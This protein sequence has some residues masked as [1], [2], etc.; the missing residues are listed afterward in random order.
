MFHN[1]IVSLPLHEDLQS[2]P[3]MLL[4]GTPWQVLWAESLPQS[5][6]MGGLDPDI[7]DN[8][9]A[10]AQP[11]P[12]PKHHQAKVSQI[13]YD[14]GIRY[15]RHG[16]LELAI[17][18]F[19]TAIRHNPRSAASQYQLGEVYLKA[20]RYEEAITALQDAIQLQP[21]YAEAYIKL[22]IVLGHAGVWDEAM[23]ALK[24]GI[25]FCNTPVI[26]ATAYHCLG[27]IHAQLGQYPLALEEMLAA[28]R[29]DP[30]LGMAYYDL[31]VLYS[32]FGEEGLA[33]QALGEAMQL[34]PY[35]AQ[36]YSQ[37]MAQTAANTTWDQPA[38]AA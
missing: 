19:K 25:V 30:A 14:M 17:Q 31:A 26:S 22:G 29:L 7:L 6:G 24:T 4:D 20:G 5:T 36:I 12:L 34:E 23:R 3:D 11:D 21:A 8:Q 2:T 27:K 32:Q 16:A 35:V 10:E 37:W 38:E 9:T 15:A 18:E 13:H 33:M 1:A 28:L